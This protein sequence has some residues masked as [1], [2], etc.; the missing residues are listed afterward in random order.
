MRSI[1]LED[2]FKWDGDL[3]QVI[4]VDHD[5]PTELRI[6]RSSDLAIRRANTVELLASDSFINCSAGPLPELASLGILERL[7]ESERTRVLTI[8]RCLKQASQEAPDSPASW[9]A[10]AAAS[11]AK[12]GLQLSERTMRRYRTAYRKVGVVG[13]VDKRLLPTTRPLHMDPRL[14]GL[15][16]DLMAAQTA[17]STGTKSRLIRRLRWAAE[18]QQIPVPADRTLYRLLDDLDRGRSTFGQATTRRSKAVRPN[19]TYSTKKVTRPGETVEIDSTRLDVDVLMPDGS[20]GRPEL[21]YAIDVATQ[22]ICATLLRTDATKSIDVGA[23]M[24]ARMLIP[25][26]ARPG[27]PQTLSTARAIFPEI[28]DMATW[29]K[30]AAKHP[31]IVPE[32]ITIDRGKVFT[33]RDFAHAC[34]R[35]EVTLIKANPRQATD[36]PNVEGGFKRIRDG[37][38]QF[39]TGYTGGSVVHRGIGTSQGALWSFNELQV[40]LDLW[41]L[42]DWQNRPQSRLLLESIP[43]HSL[44]PNQMYEALSGACPTV[45]VAL[46][47]DDYIALMSVAW[48]AVN[49]YGINLHGLVY[50]S[51]LLHPFRGRRSGYGGKARS[52][53]EVRYDPYNLAAIWLRTPEGTWIEAEWTLAGQSVRPFSLDVLKAARQALR[54]TDNEPATALSLLH[55]IN[56]IQT[57][58]ARSAVE[59]RAARSNTTAPRLVPQEEPNKLVGPAAGDTEPEIAA[60]APQTRQPPVRRLRLLD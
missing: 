20:T 46:T 8:E 4:A 19:R 33:G 18:D 55:E 11:A 35:L 45:A 36:K 42:T 28:P 57:G 5:E 22:S 29:N 53:W 2:W 30:L 14:I 3:W 23:L 56:R 24:L 13:I 37:F 6:Q 32:S 12:E 16:E 1:G 39:L 27:W 7:S 58:R 52:G 48:R 50:D 44:T 26:P 34:E 43:G 15:A 54:K 49:P 59:Q 17:A 47:R 10:V 51:P 21:T 25:L 9:S 38:V 60:P 31:L 41:V 40:L